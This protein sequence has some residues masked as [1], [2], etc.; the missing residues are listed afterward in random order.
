MGQS[1]LAAKY[2]NYGGV[3]AAKGQKSVAMMSPEGYGSTRTMQRSNFAA[4]SSPDEFFPEWGKF[5][6]DPRYAKAVE[7]DTPK[8]YA[9]GLK[10]GGYYTDS[11]DK[12]AR[13]IASTSKDIALIVSLLDRYKPEQVQPRKPES[14]LGYTVPIDQR[15]TMLNK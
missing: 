2:H 7:A 1:E 12:Y 11:A 15:Y 14:V 5:L 4:F 9:M 6:S 13:S 10:Q 8:E 3:K